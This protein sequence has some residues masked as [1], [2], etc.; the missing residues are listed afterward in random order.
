MQQVLV[1]FLALLIFPDPQR[2]GRRKKGSCLG[3][4][5][6]GGHGGPK[7]ANFDEEEEAAGVVARVVDVD[8]AVEEGKE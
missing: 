4:V 1:V 7:A 2:F 5:L 3:S 6:A 8:D